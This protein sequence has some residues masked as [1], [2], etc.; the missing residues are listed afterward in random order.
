M[1]MHEYGRGWGRGSRGQRW[2]LPLI[3]GVLL[4]AA[5]VGAFSV[6][7]AFT[8]GLRDDHFNAVVPG[9][10]LYAPQQQ[11]APQAQP[12]QRVAPYDQRGVAPYNQH[13]RIGRGF[14]RGGYGGFGFFGPLR[15]LGALSL[16]GIGAWLIFGGRRNSGNPGGTGGTPGGSAPATNVPVTPDPPATGETRM[17]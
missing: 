15:L 2:M 5:L 3:V 10:Q 11:Y 1:G 16:L 8:G 12:Q 14:D 7:R 13:D 17:L 9:Q 6:G 4:G